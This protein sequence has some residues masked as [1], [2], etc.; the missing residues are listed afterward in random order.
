M[1]DKKTRLT[2]S[3]IVARATQ[4][5]VEFDG[6]D[7]SYPSR[8]DTAVLRSFS[9]GV[10]KGEA[11]ALVGSSGCGKSTCAALLERFY[12]P[13]GGEVRLGG[14]D[15]K[16]MPLVSLRRRV[17]FVGQEPRLFDC[18]I[19]DNIKFGKPDAT[20]AE[21]IAAAKKANCHEFVTSFPE[22]YDTPCG[23]STRL[24][25]G[26]KQRVAIARALIAR[27]EVLL[28]DEPTSALDGGEKAR[29]SDERSDDI[30][31]K[32]CHVHPPSFATRFARR[33]RRS[34]P[35]TA[36]LSRHSLGEGGVAGH[37]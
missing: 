13:D 21:V 14:Q 35:K 26:Q 31:V 28:L 34:P 18:S 9:L 25:G 5:A 16:G 19:R 2:F 3:L 24:S 15:I 8:P 4:F 6:V 37:S 32:Q 27:P 33:F 12:D 36:V 10:R 11:L 7:F 22:G 29:S 30:N 23:E 1:I 17:A 20:E